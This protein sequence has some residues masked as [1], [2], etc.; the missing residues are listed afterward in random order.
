MK[1]VADPRLHLSVLVLAAACVF[2]V[3]S[4]IQLHLLFLCSISYVALYRHPL[5]AVK[6]S[7]AFVTGA[8][9]LRIL[10]SSVGVVTIMVFLMLRMMPMLAIGSLLWSTPPGVIMVAG[11]KLRMPRMVLVMICV[12]MRLIPVIR[13]EMAVIQQG[14]RARGLLPHWYS[15]LLHPK[16]SYEC[17]V[18]PLII[19][20]LRLSGEITCAAEFRGMESTTP[21]S[22]IYTIAKGRRSLYSFSAYA[23]LCTAA[24]LLTGWL[25]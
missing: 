19:R 13:E 8:A 20:G 15:I 10:P 12:F 11:A 7:A 23:L 1:T 5:R 22:T 2:C 6:L 9:L 14:I 24:M 16:R 18:L 4:E 17:F 3:Q 25:P 21:R